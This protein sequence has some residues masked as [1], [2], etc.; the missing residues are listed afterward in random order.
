M[1]YIIIALAAIAA[2]LVALVLITGQRREH[3]EQVIFRARK[4]VRK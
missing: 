1:T 3:N 4:E 2:I